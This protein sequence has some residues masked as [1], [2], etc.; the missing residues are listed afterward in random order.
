M[1]RYLLPSALILAFGLA[2][3]GAQTITKSIQLTQD[4]RSPIGMD[5][6]NNAYFPAHV[7]AGFNQNTVPTLTSCGSGGSPA[8][9]GTDQAGSVTEGAGTGAGVTSCILTF[10]SAWNT[11]P[12]CTVSTI[13]PAT[14]LGFGNAVPST[15]S[16]TIVHS[17]ATSLGWMYVC[18]SK[19]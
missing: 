1:K 14:G 19:S 8:V 2:L 11:A 15:T 10:N 6:S 18:M 5:A 16:F 3:A 9:I 13:G 17:A 7:G 4:P 12:I